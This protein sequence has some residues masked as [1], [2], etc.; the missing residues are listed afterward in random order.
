MNKV[1]V[2]ITGM[3][4]GMCEAH[5]CDAIRREFPEAKKVRASRKNCEADFI[6]EEEI[7]VSRLERAITE[8]GYTFVS[9]SQE[10]FVKHGLFSK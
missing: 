5:V 10:P 6:T 7:D 2:K 8:T 1:T 3:S 4:C 9:V